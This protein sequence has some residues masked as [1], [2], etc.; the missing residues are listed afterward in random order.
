MAWKLP[1]LRMSEGSL[2][3][4][5]LRSPWWVSALVALGLFGFTRL[6]LPL[7]FAL[8][9]ALPFGVI[10]VIRGWRQLDAP[11]PKRLAAIT[12]SVRA[13]GWEAFSRTLTEAWQ[14]DGATVEAIRHSSADFVVERNGRRTVV[15]ARRWKA[16]RSGIEVLEALQ[17]SRDRLDAHD[18]LFIATGEITE[19]ARA[20]AAKH[21]IRLGGP[22]MLLDLLEPR[23]STRR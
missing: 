14:R 21:L 10:A 17:G 18:A 5:L 9:F 13:M 2:F 12:E 1:Q 6:F 7:L 16:A 11:S 22:E 19:Q 20:Y 15:G 4:I 3:A 8:L 23:R